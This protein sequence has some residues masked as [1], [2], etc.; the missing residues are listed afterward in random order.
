M[1][2]F[3]FKA[4]NRFRAFNPCGAALVVDAAQALGLC[5]TE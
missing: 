3:N 1:V 5:H 4:F 2:V